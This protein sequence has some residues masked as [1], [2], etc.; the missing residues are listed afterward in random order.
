MSAE[1]EK[2]E[3]VGALRERFGRASIAIL[4]EPRGLT[5]GKVTQLR[6]KM[7]AI[8]GEYKIAKNTLARRA[9]DDTT[10]AQL[11][12]LLKGPT[13][14]VFGYGDP[15]VLTKE[16]VG[17]ASQNS[18]H[19]TIKAAL[20]D[21]QLFSGEQVESLARL[22]SKDQLRAKLLGVLSAPASRLLRTL[23][24]TGASLARV[25]AARGE[26]GAPADG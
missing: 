23:N 4:A 7:R 21:G 26:G 13:A 24:E 19:L 15:M 5:V 2:A 12:P 9:V 17:Y 10:F 14:L 22:E 25:L 18:Q 6:K 16:V 11:S 1:Q 20:L 3:A 8:E